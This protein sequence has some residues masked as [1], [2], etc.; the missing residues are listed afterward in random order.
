MSVRIPEERSMRP[1]C[2]FMLTDPSLAS[3]ARLIMGVLLPLPLLAASTEMPESDMAGLSELREVVQ[4][5]RPCMD[6]P[7]MDW[8]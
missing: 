5:P 8:W 1:C 6:E 4:S 7:M 2:G 3:A